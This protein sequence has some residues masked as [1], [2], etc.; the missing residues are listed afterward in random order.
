VDRGADVMVYDAQYSLERDIDAIA[1]LPRERFDGAIVVSLHHPRVSEMFLR[2]KIA[3]FPFVVVDH[4]LEEIDLPTVLHDNHGGGYLC[5]QEL[6]RRG[7][8]RIAYVGPLL[9]STRMRLEGL[10]DAINDAGIAFDRKLIGDLALPDITQD[11]RPSIERCVRDVLGQSPRPTAIVVHRSN[12][13]QFVYQTLRA[14]GLKIGRDISVVAFGEQA[15]LTMLEPLPTIV[16]VPFAEL[17][18]AA[19]EILDEQMKDPDR[20]AEHRLLP[21]RWVDGDSVG[22]I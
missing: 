20:P 2:L 15:S 14:M 7:H 16:H 12:D 18:T 9:P 6:M 17:G 10:R 22:T 21:T 3:R 5:A 19:M 13:L 8:R 1:H 11:S 4:Q